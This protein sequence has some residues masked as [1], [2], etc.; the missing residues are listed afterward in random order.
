MNKSVHW[1]IKMASFW[2]P[3]P[4]AVMSGWRRTPP[5]RYCRG[6]C[7]VSW[8]ETSHWFKLKGRR[9]KSEIQLEKAF[10]L[11]D[12]SGLLTS[13]PRLSPVSTVSRLI[14]RAPTAAPFP[15]KLPSLTDSEG[16]GGNFSVPP[17][18]P[19]RHR[20]V[21][22]VFVCYSFL[23]AP[24]ARDAYKQMFGDPWTTAE[25]KKLPKH[26][27]PRSTSLCSGCFWTTMQH[28][29]VL[30]VLADGWLS[31]C[32]GNPFTADILS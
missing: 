28:L 32:C 21:Q 23:I 20:D 12:T 18:K 10:I 11:C 24:G 5:L 29:L 27:L 15:E 31:N 8:S 2:I 3:S 16:E 25:I 1:L 9:G 19:V 22:P 4:C 14:K 17:Q 7:R 13:E 6:R 30:R 26:V